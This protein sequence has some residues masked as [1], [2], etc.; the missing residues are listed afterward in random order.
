MLTIKQ[1]TFSPFQENTYVIYNDQ[2]WSAIVDPGCYF[3]EERTQLKEF[4]EKLGLQPKFLLNTH[5]HLDHIFGAN[6]VFETFKLP[7]HLHLSEKPVLDK[8]AE[9]GERWGV[10]VDPFLGTVIFLEEGDQVVIGEDVLDVVFT[11]GHSPGSISFYCKQQ[12]FILNGDVLFRRG[13]GRTD[14]PGGNY[15][16]L[17]QTILEKLYQLPDE[18]VVY[19]GHGPTTTIG[20]E[21]RNNPFVVYTNR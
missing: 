8:A 19:S 20:Y 7:M 3:R 1:F 13:I 9:S 11:P 5:C 14:L 2:G 16:T 21:K 4:I 15:E 18:T 10:P 17:E 12:Q 6:F